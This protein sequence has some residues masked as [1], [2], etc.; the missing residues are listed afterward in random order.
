MLQ[1]Y[2]KIKW[3]KNALH[4]RLRNACIVSLSK[5]T[6]PYPDGVDR[7]D[8]QCRSLS[9]RSNYGKVRAN[10]PAGAKS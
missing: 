3:A 2:V 9:C 8:K 7:A 6:N 4:E 10:G 1:Y 5:D